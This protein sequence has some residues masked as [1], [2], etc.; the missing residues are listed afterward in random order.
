MLITFFLHITYI[1]IKYLETKG[2]P[3]LLWLINEKCHSYEFMCVAWSIK[4]DQHNHICLIFCDFKCTYWGKLFGRNAEP[5]SSL[6]ISVVPPAQHT[7]LWAAADKEVS[8]S[9][10]VTLRRH[11]SLV[12]AWSQQSQF[13]SSFPW[14]HSWISLSAPSGESLAWTTF[15]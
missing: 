14:N 11:T 13:R 4:K 2:K 15:L 5:G 1:L 9:H 6:W 8:D 10:C 3:L 7:D 12:L